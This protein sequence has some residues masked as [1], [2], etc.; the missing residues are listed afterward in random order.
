[1]TIVAATDGNHGRAVAR[2][3][4][5]L[6][7]RARIF[8]PD[9]VHP[10][11]VQAIRDEGA[12]VTTVPA[13]YDEAVRTAARYAADTGGV[14]VQDTAWHGYEEVPGWIV[15]GYSTLFRELDV[16]LAD[17][18][19]AQPDMVLVPDRGRVAAAGR[20]HPLPGR[21]TVRDPAVVSVEPGQP[22]CVQASI[23]A[24][25]PVSVATGHTIM[26]GLNCGTVSSLAWPS[27]HRGLD[28]AA[29]VT[30][31]QVTLGRPGPRR[32][33]ASLSAAVRRG[34][35]RRSADTRS[36]RSVSSGTTLVLIATEGEAANPVASPPV[37]GL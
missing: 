8:V 26:A 30:D 33:T 27:I 25:H 20:S 1:M 34:P 18:G 21:R 6:G 9:G 23:A 32:R 5:L 29:T 14:L 28:A 15:D 37:V 2:F 3:S 7:H 24:G 11:A 4:R 10:A 36:D 22:R 12:D 16:Q 19:I 31:D 13:D 17:L 35:A